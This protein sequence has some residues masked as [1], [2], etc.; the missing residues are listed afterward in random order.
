MQNL[1]GVVEKCFKGARVINGS[2]V[3]FGKSVNDAS[4]ML[5]KKIWR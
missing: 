1:G 4:E 5:V 2:A 3:K